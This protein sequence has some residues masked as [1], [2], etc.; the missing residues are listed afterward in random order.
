MCV[1]TVCECGF[2]A[3]LLTLPVGVQYFVCICKCVNLIG[4]L[5]EHVPVMSEHL[6][7][8]LCKGGSLYLCACL[9]VYQPCQCLFPLWFCACV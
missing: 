5:C 6:L 1:Q 8:C 9:S 7:E 4:Q 3:Y 2:S